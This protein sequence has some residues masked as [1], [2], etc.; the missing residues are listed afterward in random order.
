MRKEEKSHR[1]VVCMRKQSADL[2]R[3]KP[4]RLLAA[5]LAFVQ[6]FLLLPTTFPMPAMASPDMELHI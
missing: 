4:K 1:E 5:M 3:T 6:V 2:N